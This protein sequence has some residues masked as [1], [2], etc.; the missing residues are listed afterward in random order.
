MDPEFEHLFLAAGAVGAG[1]VYTRHVEAI[2]ILRKVI[3]R[4][5]AKL[6]YLVLKLH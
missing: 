3:L 5:S 6:D 2:Q 1:A 4:I